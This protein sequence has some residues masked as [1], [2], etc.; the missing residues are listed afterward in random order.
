MREDVTFES[1]GSR[2]AGWLYRPPAASAPCVVMAHGFG[3]V[4][5]ARLDAYAERFQERGFAV[6]VFDYRHFGASDGEPRQLL[7]IARQLEDWMAAVAYART[8]PGVD[9]VRI[10]L[11]G[12]SFSAGHVVSVAARDPEVAAVVAQVPFADGIATTVRMSPLLVGKLLLKGLADAAGALAGR[13]PVTVPIVG[14]PGSIACLTTPDAEPGYL[15]LVPPGCAFDNRVA[16]RICLALPR[17]RPGRLAGRVRCP[18]L[19]CVA[20]DDVVTPPA[21]A[22]SAANRAPRGELRRYPGGHFDLYLGETFERV[23]ADQLDFLSRH[24]LERPR[25]DVARDAESRAADLRGKR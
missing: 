6:L 2:C 14:P 1:G 22:I 11:W 21:A 9:P 24:L 18:A 13:D 16:A 7:D 19:F 17:Y 10:A 23:I 4:K 3:G 8:L 5:E 12:T 20:A 15:A 25:A